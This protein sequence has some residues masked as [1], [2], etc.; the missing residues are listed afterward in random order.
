MSRGVDDVSEHITQTR[1]LD[2]G[3]LR[4]ARAVAGWYLGYASW[5]DQIIGAYLNPEE[6]L[7]N[8]RREKGEDDA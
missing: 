6:A 8:L 5:A 2:E 4:A 7:K 3:G 1:A